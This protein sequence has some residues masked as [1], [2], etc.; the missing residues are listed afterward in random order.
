MPESSAVVSVFGVEHMER[1]PHIG[2]WILQN[3]PA[4]V[5]VETACHPSHGAWPGNL[6]TCAD[7]TVMGS[8]GFFQRV[9]C[10]VAAAMQEQGDAA[11]APDGVWRQACENFNGEQLAYVAALAT[12]AKL[13]F[14]DRPKEITYRRLFGL[15]SL[16]Q[17]DEAFAYEV[18][19]QYHQILGE[20]KPSGSCV[21]DHMMMREREVV[22]CKVAAD[23][24]ANEG[25]VA[26]VVGSAHVPGIR[27][28]WES[29]Q[30]RQLL[31]TDDLAASPLMSAPDI[32]PQDMQAP[33]SGVRRGLL[34]A[35]LA[36]SVPDEVL[37]DLD[38]HLPAVPDEQDEERQCTFEVYSCQRTQLAVLPR[39][40]LDRVVS[41]APGCASGRSMWE[42]LE[43]IRAVR[44]VNGG[45]GWDEDLVVA[46][47][48]LDMYISAGPVD[49]D[50]MN[51]SV[52]AAAA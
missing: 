1:Q 48:A 20:K 25:S 47:R 46:L 41:C 22:M 17:L 2:D 29:Q 42:V 26:L 44:P 36:L 34:E 21:V 15:P 18:L 43:P 50:T 31:R 10:Q 6:F 23:L 45:A 27:E 49:E 14:G 4:A 3:R 40:V 16:Q 28:L 5:V 12:G 39:D 33:G 51:D 32:R 37:Q 19:S 52:G 24:A 9:F 11:M 38:G 13:A 7:Q 30:W 35:V 8:D